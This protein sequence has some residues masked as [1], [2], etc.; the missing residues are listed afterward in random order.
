MR[1]PRFVFVALIAAFGISVFFAAM[2]TAKHVGVSRAAVIRNHT[3][4]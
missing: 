3:H 1:R 4:G 2:T